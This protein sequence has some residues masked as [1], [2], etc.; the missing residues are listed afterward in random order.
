[1]RQSSVRKGRLTFTAQDP[2]TGLVCRPRHLDGRR[3]W[4]GGER[5]EDFRFC[6]PWGRRVPRKGRRARVG[7][8]FLLP[9][10]KV[11]PKEPGQVE[12]QSREGLIA[13]GWECAPD[14]TIPSGPWGPF[15]KCQTFGVSATQRD[16]PRSLWPEEGGEL[17]TPSLR[18]MQ[19]TQAQEGEARPTFLASA[20][21]RLP[22][23]SQGS[24][25]I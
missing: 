4:P 1:M 3:D 2:G 21:P 6:V 11:P 12:W 15:C 18:Q 23:P 25:C 14:I 10:S 7:A 24:L 19:K 20:P 22:A 9:F 13:L 5:H 17:P 16:S 8:A